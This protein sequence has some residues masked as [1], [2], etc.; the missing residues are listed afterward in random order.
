MFPD[1]EKWPLCA[2]SFALERKPM[3]RITENRPSK[4][5]EVTLAFWLIKILG[6]HPG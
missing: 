1:D 4:V 3:N 2:D 6:D 5:P